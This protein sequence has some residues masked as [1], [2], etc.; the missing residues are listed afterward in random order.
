MWARCSPSSSPTLLACLRSSPS[1]IPPISVPWQ[2]R[3][4]IREISFAPPGLIVQ[5]N[6]R[7]KLA[8]QGAGPSL[9]CCP[10]G[11]CGAQGNAPLARYPASITS[12]CPDRLVR[13]DVSPEA[14]VRT[15]MVPVSTGLGGCSLPHGRGFDTSSKLAIMDRRN[16][17]L[18]SRSTPGKPCE[19]A[20][21]KRQRA[22]A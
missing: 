9:P 15:G 11:A 7:G 20:Q 8:D 12:I 19:G 17:C 5:A 2:V 6:S 21:G 10:P 16:A 18:G 4:G 22:G 3:K 14:P 13:S 1:R